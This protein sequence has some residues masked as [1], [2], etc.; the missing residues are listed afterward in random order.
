MSASTINGLA[1]ADSV[2]INDDVASA[3]NVSI[4]LAGGADV[5]TASG[6]DFSSSEIL[7]GAGGDSIQAMDAQFGGTLKLGDGNDSLTMTAGELDSVYGG[8]GAD[9]IIGSA[10]I[11]GS[12]ALIAL[13]AGSDTLTLTDDFHL[14]SAEI[15]GG[16]GA[17][18]VSLSGIND[19][20][21]ISI[22]L[23]SSV[24]G[25]GADTLSFKATAASASIKGKGGK[26]VITI[27]NGSQLEA[28]SQVLGNAGADSIVL[29][30]TFGADSNVTIGGGSGNDTLVFT[31]TETGS[32]VYGGGGRDSLNIDGQNEANGGG[33]IYGGAGT[34]SITFSADIAATGAEYA[35][36]IGFQS[37]T[38]STAG[39]A[40]LITF[41]NS[42]AYSGTTTATTGITTFNI[43]LDGLGSAHT[44]EAPGLNSASI[45]S[46]VATFS[47]VSAVSDRISKV[48]ALITTTG[49]YAIFGDT[50]SDISAAYL[51]IQGGA[52][53]IVTK[54]VNSNGAITG[55]FTEAVAGSA[56]SITM[57]NSN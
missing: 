2:Q 39:S 36:A 11:S 4:N 8:N 54:F 24:N 34:D 31:A 52:N 38:D 28:S 45:T 25:G 19:A 5:L 51:F 23:D 53:D 1:G 26:D 18:S 35:Q 16:G 50:D 12:A 33:T 55:L 32:V 47:S 30:D 22:N 17:D 27:E 37:F 6:T 42:V 49:Q 3:K 56:F 57:G 29:D 40:D 20:D 43:A 9:L 14:L 13:G 15:I 21:G 46:G 7:M 10:T 48:D 41:T 44:A